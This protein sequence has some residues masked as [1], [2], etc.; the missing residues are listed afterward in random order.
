MKVFHLPQLTLAC[1]QSI[2]ETPF[3]NVS[4][5]DLEQANVNLVLLNQ[6]PNSQYSEKSSLEK[7]LKNVEDAVYFFHIWSP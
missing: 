4:I 3:S 1:L 7:M 5:V 6:F 2:T